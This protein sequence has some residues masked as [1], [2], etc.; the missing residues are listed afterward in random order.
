LLNLKK[1]LWEYLKEN[2]LTTLFDLK[3]M[4]N[5]MLVSISQDSQEIEFY[6]NSIRLCDLK[7]FHWYFKLVEMEENHEEKE[8]SAHISQLIGFNVDELKLIKD[9]E[10][11]EYRLDLFECVSARLREENMNIKENKG[12]NLLLFQSMYAPQLEVDPNNFQLDINSSKSLQKNAKSIDICIFGDTSNLSA[13]SKNKRHGINEREFLERE[14]IL[15]VSL[16]T[17]PAN[18]LGHYFRE[19]YPAESV[20]KMHQFQ[21]TYLLNVCGTEEVLFGNESKLYSYKVIYLEYFVLNI[22]TTFFLL[23]ENT[24]KYISKCISNNK[25]P[26]FHIVLI[27]SL[28]NKIPNENQQLIMFID[29]S[30]EEQKRELEF[31]AENNSFDSK[32]KLSWECNENFSF[33]LDSLVFLPPLNDCEKVKIMFSLFFRPLAFNINDTFFLIDFFTNR[34]LSWT[35]ASYKHCRIE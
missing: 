20:D 28:L 24:F 22:L 15:N 12:L 21:K 31:D 13:S 32:S 35:R 34:Y 4:S 5:Y 9:P 25:M 14:F 26:R 1:K 27:Q 11:L 7:L 3:Y 33:Y 8:L 17:T 6:D 16:D 19:K 29:K 2:N 10:L 18:L 30:I 23:F